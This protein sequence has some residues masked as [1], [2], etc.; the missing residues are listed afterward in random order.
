MTEKK[1][2]AAY[3]EIEITNS[4]DDDSVLK[5]NAVYEDES[6]LFIVSNMMV[7]D[8]QALLDRVKIPFDEL[9]VC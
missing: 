2:K 9:V 3:N 5:I 1:L 8:L 4:I 7:C 6:N